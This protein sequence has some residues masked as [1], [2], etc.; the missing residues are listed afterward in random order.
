[1]KALK[2]G[3][4]NGL[5]FKQKWAEVL[6]K[7]MNTKKRFNTSYFPSNRKSAFRAF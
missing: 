7:Q 4:K 5:H 1:M 6:P 2:Q 3:L